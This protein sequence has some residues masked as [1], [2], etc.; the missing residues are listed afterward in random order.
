MVNGEG[1]LDP[2]SVVAYQYC[3]WA[4]DFNALMISLEHRFYGEVKTEL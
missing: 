1:P 3:T 4:Q 2:L